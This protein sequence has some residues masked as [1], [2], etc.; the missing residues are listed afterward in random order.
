MQVQSILIAILAKYSTMYLQFFPIVILVQIISK[1]EA[2]FP[3][4][5]GKF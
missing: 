4:Q 2:S 3:A 1:L 5:N